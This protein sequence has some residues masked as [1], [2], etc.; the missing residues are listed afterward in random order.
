MALKSFLI[1]P[2]SIR[3]FSIFKS[4]QLKLAAER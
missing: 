1:P 4:R 3:R 2:Y